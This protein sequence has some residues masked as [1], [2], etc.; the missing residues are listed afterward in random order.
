MYDNNIG[1]CVLIARPGAVNTAVCEDRP[2]Q[3]WGVQ[4]AVTAAAAAVA[5]TL[6]WPAW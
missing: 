5:P 1:L 3:H 2:D 6:G 4:K